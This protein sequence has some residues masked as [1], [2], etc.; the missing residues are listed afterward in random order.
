MIQNVQV[1]LSGISTQ[2]TQILQCM[3]DSYPTRE[4]ESSEDQGSSSGSGQ[5]GPEAPVE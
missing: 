3:P 5:A 2:L 1:Q 4:P